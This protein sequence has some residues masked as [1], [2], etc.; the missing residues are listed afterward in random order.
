[1]AVISI[2]GKIGS[3][4]D[5]IADIISQY[6]EKLFPLRYTIRDHTKNIISFDVEQSWQTFFKLECP[7][8][9]INVNIMPGYCLTVKP[10]HGSHKYIYEEPEEIEEPEEGEDL[11]KPNDSGDNITNYKNK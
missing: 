5:T 1:M 2:S 4:K 8:I 11:E 10:K 9:S 7:Y 3:G 6:D